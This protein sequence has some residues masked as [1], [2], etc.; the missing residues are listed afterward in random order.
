[1]RRIGA[2]QGRCTRLFGSRRPEERERRPPQASSQSSDHLGEFRDHA[3]NVS[4]QHVGRCHLA[5][6]FRPA[7]AE[8]AFHASHEVEEVRL[9]Q[10]LQ[11]GEIEG[12]IADEAVLEEVVGNPLRQAVAERVLDVPPLLPRSGLVPCVLVQPGNDRRVDVFGHHQSVT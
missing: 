11:G 2:P 10:C 7:L 5:V 4:T 12:L 6:R 3:L 9:D 1:M 8:G